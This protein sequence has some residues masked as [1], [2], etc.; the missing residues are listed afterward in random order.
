MTSKYYGSE[1]LRTQDVS[2]LGK[3]VADILGQVFLGIYHLDGS[4]SNLYKV[5]WRE[6]YFIEINI[7]YGLA[8]F[9]FDH[10]TRLVTLCHDRMIR[11]E[12]KPC[13]FRYM[14]LIFH[15]R[16]V[17]EGDISE[18]MP[19]LESHVQSIR[20]NIGLDILEVKP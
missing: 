13:N 15:Q 17:R 4:Q 9:D 1:W 12:I 16:K 3:E 6:K 5:N 7:S 14:K 19:T 11:L 8:T 10:L 2:P 18:R 20:E